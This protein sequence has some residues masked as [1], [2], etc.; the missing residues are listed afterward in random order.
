MV[1]HHRPNNISESTKSCAG[2]G[3]S[4]LSGQGLWQVWQSECLRLGLSLRHMLQ[5]N[6]ERDTANQSA[7]A[8]MSCDPEGLAWHH[9]SVSVGIDVAS[10]DADEADKSPMV[11]APCTIVSFEP[12]NSLQFSCFICGRVVRALVCSLKFE[13]S[14]PWLP[15]FL[16]TRVHLAGTRAP[17]KFEVWRKEKKKK[18]KKSVW[19]PMLLQGVWV[20]IKEFFSSKISIKGF[21][22]Y[23][24]T[25]KIIWPIYVDQINIG[26]W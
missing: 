19:R 9:G 11:V 1:Q 21:L 3:G 14:S 26:I 15:K 18:E 13:C 8:P 25:T 23:L 2:A 7:A 5:L 16:Q 10:V 22:G 17:Q 24:K 4:G 12:Q 6:E 20:K